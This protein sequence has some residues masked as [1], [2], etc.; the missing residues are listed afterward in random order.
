[1]INCFV[2]DVKNINEINIIMLQKKLQNAYKILN[3][4]VRMRNCK[5]CFEESSQEQIDLGN[6][7]K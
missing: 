4:K 2:K 6:C 7:G 1:M 5:L 3:N